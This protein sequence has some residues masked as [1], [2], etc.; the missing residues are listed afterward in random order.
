M[1]GLLHIPAALLEE[2]QP[3]VPTGQEAVW[4]PESVSM[5]HREKNL[6]PP[7]EMQQR[8]LG[9]AARSLVAVP[10]VLS[11]LPTDLLCNDYRRV[12]RTER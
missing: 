3:P 7:P 6:L 10:T 5:L 11:R 1:G 2:K 8:L 4:A 12:T 9:R